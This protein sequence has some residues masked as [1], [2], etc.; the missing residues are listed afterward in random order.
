MTAEAVAMKPVPMQYTGC[1]CEGDDGKDKHDQCDADADHHGA[2]SGNDD[3]GG[4][5]DD[6]D[7]SCDGGCGGGDDCAADYSVTVSAMTMT[8]I[9]AMTLGSMT[10]TLVLPS[11]LFLDRLRKEADN[12]VHKISDERSH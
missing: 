7:S 2:D 12:F 5:D 9:V 6:D 8:L 4:D 1:H 3:G 10:A 11:W